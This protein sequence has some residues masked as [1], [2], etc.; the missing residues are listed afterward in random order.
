M[1]KINFEG[2]VPCGSFMVLTTFTVAATNKE[3]LMKVANQRAK[4][5]GLEEFQSVGLHNRR[6]DWE[7]IYGPSKPDHRFGDDNV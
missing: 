3:D 7:E 1:S 5:L 4:E 2:Y 6:A